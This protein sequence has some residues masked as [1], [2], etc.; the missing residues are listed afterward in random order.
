MKEQKMKSKVNNHQGIKLQ[1][2][3]PYIQN[4]LNAHFTHHTKSNEIN[5]I[6]WKLTEII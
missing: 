5:N 4:K 6:Q 2:P 1:D 3:Q